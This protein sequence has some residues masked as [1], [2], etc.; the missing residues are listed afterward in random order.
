MRDDWGIKMN[1]RAHFTG[2]IIAGLSVAVACGGVGLG[3]S[4]AA[5]GAAAALLMSM[6]PDLDTHSTPSKWFYTLL[7]P[8]C[9]YL[10]MVGYS[11]IAFWTLVVSVIPKMLSHRGLL[12]H[13]L[14][15]I[16]L[17]ASVFALPIPQVMQLVVYVA[18]VIGFYTHLLLDGEIV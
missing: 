9:I 15:G 14:T 4:V 1:F 16:I 3:S 17:P 13:K 12:H 5:A 2:G 11:S 6:F 8:A 10:W 7:A 18:A